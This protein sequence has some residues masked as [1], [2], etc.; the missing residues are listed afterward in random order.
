MKVVRYG[1][2]D[3]KVRVYEGK[4]EIPV[5]STVKPN[6]LFYYERIMSKVIPAF[7]LVAEPDVPC[8]LRGRGSLVVREIDPRD[9]PFVPESQLM[10]LLDDGSTRMITTIRRN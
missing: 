4:K 10:A 3:N 9:C 1:E 2:E 5:E 7:E 8:I 6:S